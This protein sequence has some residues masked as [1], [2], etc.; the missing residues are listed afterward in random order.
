MVSEARNTP[1]R[2]WHKE[3]GAPE[4][5]IAER[6]QRYVLTPQV[7]PT[8]NLV[9]GPVL[10]RSGAISLSIVLGKGNSKLSFRIMKHPEQRPAL[11][12]R[13]YPSYLSECVILR[14]S[15]RIWPMR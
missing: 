2:I 5:R 7:F 1:E 8:S 12:V 9:L 10:H 4:I 15:R 11:S 6:F 14:R 13:A 3:V